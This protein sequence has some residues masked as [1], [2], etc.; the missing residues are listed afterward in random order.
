MLR[1]SI[2]ITQTK[3]YSQNMSGNRYAYANANMAE[4]EVLHPYAH[5]L[6]NRAA[7]QNKPDGTAVIM[8]QISLKAGLKRWG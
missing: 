1:S 3:S 7:V 6:F 5:M 8:N 4:H 2:V